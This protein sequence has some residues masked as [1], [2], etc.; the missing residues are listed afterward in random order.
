MDTRF[1]R[2]CWAAGASWAILGL[3][4]ATQAANVKV[5]PV[6]DADKPT[7]AKVTVDGKPFC[8]YHIRSGHQ[9]IIWPI[10]GPGGQPLTRA[11]PMG[12]QAAGGSDDHPHHR[13]LW[14][15]HGSVNGLDFWMEPKAPRPD[16]QIVHREFAE[17]TA[18]DGV[19]KIVARDDWTSDG[20]K[21]AEDERT[22]TF[23]ADANG[24]WIDFLVVVTASEGDLTFGDT[25]EGSLGLRVADSLSAEP[26]HGGKGGIRNS[27][28]Q[29]DAVAWGQSAEW[30]DYSGPV[31]GK[32]AGIAVFDLPDSFRHP[33]RWHVR[34]YGLFAA[35]PFGQHDFPPDVREQGATTIKKGETLKLHYR[36]LFYDGTKTNREL[37]AIYKEYA[38]EKD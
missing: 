30:V 14:F 22:I 13:S 36:V 23:G 32:P 8:E 9:P 4:A 18:A 35:N 38:G 5:E 11:Y 28:G 6:G 37:A 24:R 31:D 27:R 16:N 21:V 1:A 2:H 10:I 29:E 15:T 7:G 34:E 25:K 12:E 20:R 19:A 26:K 3:A 17:L 33:T